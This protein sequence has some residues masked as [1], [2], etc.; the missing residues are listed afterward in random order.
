MKSLFFWLALNGLCALQ[1]A[2]GA[3]TN[4]SGTAA[5][6]ATDWARGV[7]G[8]RKADLGNGFY[9]N[10]ILSGD[11]PDPSVLRVGKDYYLV[12]SSF[13]ST[14]G[15]MIWHSCDL[16]NWE[17]VGPALQKYV[18]SVWAPD[19]VHYQGK[20]Y[21]YFPAVGSYGITNM[22]VYS[23]NIRGPWSEP[24]GIGVG[25]LF[26][27]G[28]AVGPDGKRYLFLNG[29]NLAPLADDGLKTTGPAKKVYDGWKYPDDWD[30][31][32]FAQ[33]GPKVL[34]HGDYYYMVLAEGGTAGPATSHMVIMARSKS[35]E[36]PWE[37]SPY[38]P[39]VH[40]RSAAEKWWSRGHATLV[41]GPDNRHWYLVYH[42]YENGYYNLGRQTLLEPVEWTDDGWVKASGCDVAQ[43]IP[44]LPGGSAV[45]NGFAFSDD[46]RTNKIGRQ[47]SFFRCYEPIAGRFRYETNALVLKATGSSPK[48]CSPL[49]FVCGD[50]AYE[51]EVEIDCDD[52]ATAG[53][54]L[55]YSERLFV[56]LGFS[57]DKMIE[58][59][60]GDIAE[61]PKQMPI[62]RHYFVRL[63]NNH[64]IVTTWYS[65]DGEHWRKHWMQ[66]EVSGYNHNVAGG[67]LSLRPALFAAG[68]GE[69][70]FRNFKYQALP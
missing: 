60:K 17:P 13:E 5:V 64:Q 12:N 27:P 70:R 47:W 8:Q 7:E 54:L 61:F 36:G 6:P 57:R 48:D 41:E 23:D 19:L 34:R 66:F 55:F 26:D 25:N 44:V 59:G 1:L 43:P 40:T 16:V 53:L 65:P 52:T 9:L 2:V 35:L 29:G 3:E 63:R 33:E 46:F 39:V 18:G 49:T 30:V 50:Q 32:T 22:V 37:N 10:P 69:V 45:P 68:S 56:G 62:G 67:F 38:N 42:A 14:P 20:F 51:M 15:L 11:R 24:V 21:I 28:H 31:E 4:R 58:Y